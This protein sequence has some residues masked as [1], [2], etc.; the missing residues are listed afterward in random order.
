MRPRVIPS[1]SVLEA[2][3]RAG[4]G[5]RSVPACVASSAGALD[6]S[7]GC[8]WPTNFMHVYPH[9]FL[10]RPRYPAGT[11]KPRKKAP[12]S[13]R[14]RVRWDT[15]DMTVSARQHTRRGLGGIA[16]SGASSAIKKETSA[17]IERVIPTRHPYRHR[18]TA[19]PPAASRSD[20]CI[21]QKN[22]A[23]GLF[24]CASESPRCVA[25]KHAQTHTSATCTTNSAMNRELACTLQNAFERD[26]HERRTPSGRGRRHAEVKYADRR[27]PCIEHRDSDTSSIWRGTIRMR[28]HSAAPLDPRMRLTLEHRVACMQRRPR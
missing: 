25:F 4:S 23:I 18:I 3:R 21:A 13:H 7:T 15:G 28:V 17:S 11:T 16:G 2:C 6:F 1:A 8:P 9:E 5:A 20:R 14:G 10:V 22:L 27:E 12:I 24:S 19:P 26:R